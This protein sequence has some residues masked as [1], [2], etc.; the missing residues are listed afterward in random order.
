[1]AENEKEQAEEQANEASELNGGLETAQVETDIGLDGSTIE[2]IQ[3]LEKDIDEAML[4]WGF[5]RTESGKESN[6]LIFKYRL[7]AKGL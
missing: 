3:G 5:A 4:K 1:M 7:F 6:K 2:F